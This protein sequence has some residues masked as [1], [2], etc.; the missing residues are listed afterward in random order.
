MSP[1]HMMCT[2]IPL[3]LI[4]VIDVLIFPIVYISYK[5]F[6][7]KI[8][9]EINYDYMPTYLIYFR[10]SPFIIL[11]TSLSCSFSSSFFSRIVTLMWLLFLLSCSFQWCTGCFFYAC[12][13]RSLA[14]DWFDVVLKACRRSIQGMVRSLLLLTYSEEW[15]RWQ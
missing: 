15:K 4:L 9:T 14:K 3:I 7:C 1:V 6:E 8:F 13:I 10:I 12:V 5:E 11:Y 2:F